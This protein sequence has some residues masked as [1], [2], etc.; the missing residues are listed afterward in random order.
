MTTTEHDRLLA[1]LLSLRGALNLNHGAQIVLEDDSLSTLDFSDAINIAAGAIELIGGFR[2]P[3]A[4]QFARLAEVRAMAPDPVPPIP[5][6]PTALPASV[7][8]ALS[9]IPD[10]AH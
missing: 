7:L 2:V 3:I 8:A 5:R 6:A 10:S 1:A 9:A 4:D